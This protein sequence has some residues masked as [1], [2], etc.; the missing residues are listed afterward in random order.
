MKVVDVI[1]ARVLYG[2][3]ELVE[4]IEK[5]VVTSWTRKL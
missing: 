5:D 1:I 2:S 3:Y 4:V